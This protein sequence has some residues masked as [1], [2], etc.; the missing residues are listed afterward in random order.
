MGFLSETLCPRL[1]ASVHALEPRGALDRLEWHRKLRC[2]RCVRLS[3]VGALIIRIGF[4]GPCYYIHNQEPQNSI[5][6]S[7]GPCSINHSW[8]LGSSTSPCDFCCVGLSL[9]IIEIDIDLLTAPSLS[10]SPSSSSCS[11]WSED[12]SAPGP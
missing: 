4:W 2:S 11:S 6:N 3:N 1:R 12:V 7:L 9:G 8:G 5:G 10:S